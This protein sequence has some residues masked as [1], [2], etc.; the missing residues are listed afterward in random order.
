M[1]LTKINR[2]ILN[3]ETLSIEEK[4][5][6]WEMGAREV[7][8]KACSDEK[9][10]NYYSIGLKNKYGGVVEKCIEEA[11]RREIFLTPILWNLP[12]PDN[13]EDFD[14]LINDFVKLK[15]GINLN[16]DMF[17]RLK[18]DVKG[19]LTSLYNN[20]ND[21]TKN[22]HFY[23][24][25]ITHEARWIPDASE[26]TYPSPV[27]MNHDQFLEIHR[28]ILF[29]GIVYI[30]GEIWYLTEGE[31]SEK[32]QTLCDIFNDRVLTISPIT[33][34]KIGNNY[35]LKK[36]EL[37]SIIGDAIRRNGLELKE[38]LTDKEAKTTLIE[39]KTI[40]SLKISEIVNLLESK[41]DDNLINDLLLKLVD[42]ISIHHSDLEDVDS[43]SEEEKYE[44][45]KEFIDYTKLIKDQINS[46]ELES[47]EE[48]LDFI[49]ELLNKYDTNDT[50]LTEDIEKH[51]TLNPKLWNEDG[52]LKEEVHD[53]IIQIAN[54]FI[55]SLKDDGVQFD[56]KDIRIVGS[57]CSYN[58]T[59]DSDLDV[60]LIADSSSLD[61][62][63][64]L[65]PLLYSSY[66]SI[67]NK[68]LD[69]DFYGIPVEIYVEVE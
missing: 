63:H 53:K 56:L 44:I 61:C 26:L 52:T 42:I 6:L 24:S 5:K 37:I 8:V 17:L 9:L 15:E 47:S 58:Y 1:K 46:D 4:A 35:I 54:E 20:L 33:F 23:A 10:R 27:F 16:L 11:N 64:D 18:A 29:I 40:E 60:H 66:R 41:S 25:P 31:D 50:S 39:E 43:L 48:T 2:N 67:F 68:N 22:A 34:E 21:S 62:P 45:L 36:P 14:K 19:E 28:I 57:N 59:K 38:S 65:Y 12:T 69:I 55:S 32:L 13:C 30:V 7:N 49:D 51:D 3:E